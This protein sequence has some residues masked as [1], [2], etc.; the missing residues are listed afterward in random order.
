MQT[1]FSLG[2][3]STAEHYQQLLVEKFPLSYEA[4]QPKPVL[5]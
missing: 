2:S 1:E 4:K 3:L 5:Q